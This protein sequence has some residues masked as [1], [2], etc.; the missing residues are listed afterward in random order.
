MNAAPANGG[1]IGLL[2]VLTFLMFM[3]FAMTTDSVGV[4][5]PEII[6]QFSLGMTAAGSF[7]YATMSGISIAAISLG[8]LADRLG[9]KIS[10]ILG[11]SLFGVAS[12]LFAVGQSFGFFVALL[13]ISGLGIGIFKAGALALIGDISSSTREHTATMNTVEGFFGIGAIIGP[14]IVAYLLHAGAEW[15][16]LYV[17]A[18]GLCGLLILGAAGARYPKKIV[19]EAERGRFRE[20]LRLAKDPYALG[21]SVA[22]M[23]Y[24]AAEAAIYVWAPTYLA[25]YTGSLV[26]FAVY[27]VSIFFVLRAVGRFVGA[28]LLARYR[29]TT[30]LAFCS[31]GMFACFAGSA[32]FGRGAA[33]ILLPFSG[34]FMS[35]IYPTLNSKGISCF[36]KSVHGAAA[37]LLLFFT[38]ISAVLAPLAMA[39][40]SDAMGD[41]KYSLY[42]ATVFAAVLAGLTV[43]NLMADPTRARLSERDEA[44]YASTALA[45]EAGVS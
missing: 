30:V 10:I 44:D 39:A 24:V 7:Q 32:I 25:G 20:T 4:V 2:K 1:N 23:L 42:L 3:M 45:A 36:E 27:A 43:Y 31:C 5:I 11:L 9:R 40:L 26:W 22:V 21:F 28:W 38:C 37:G 14:A 18:A 19:A 33:A 35:V 15:K 17:I 13:F 8:F 12:A 34:I 29:W 16:W 6:K 41:A